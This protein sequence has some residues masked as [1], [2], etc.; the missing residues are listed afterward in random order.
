MQ[1][2]SPNPGV[3]YLTSRG[4]TIY[5]CP[6][7]R[8]FSHPLLEMEKGQSSLFTKDVFLKWSFNVSILQIKH[9]PQNMQSLVIWIS[10]HCHSKEA[11]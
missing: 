10:M 6:G 1:Q 2:L 5:F 7:E 9:F 4:A 8:F 11:T 3:A